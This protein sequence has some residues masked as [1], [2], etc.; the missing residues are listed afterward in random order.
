MAVGLQGCIAGGCIAGGCIA[1]GCTVVFINQSMYSHH[2]RV[3]TLRWGH[4]IRVRRSKVWTRL[5][6]KCFLSPLPRYRS[7]GSKRPVRSIFQPE[8]QFRV[9]E[10]WPGSS[11][12]ET[13]LEPC[14]VTLLVKNKPLHQSHHGATG[15]SWRKTVSF[16]QGAPRRRP[17]LGPF[18]ES[19]A[20]HAL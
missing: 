15:R 5:K 19:S 10:T 20:L 6:F 17:L 12:R 7:A 1:G 14:G 9:P 11:V 13:F 16:E 2:V 3:D 18:S 8:V 4:E